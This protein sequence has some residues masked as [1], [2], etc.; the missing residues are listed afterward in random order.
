MIPS[1]TT[2]AGIAAFLGAENHRGAGWAAETAA[3]RES[4]SG[5]PHGQVRVFFNDTITASIVADNGPL[6]N[7]MPHTEGSMVVKELYGSGTSVIGHAAMLRSGGQYIFY[8][9]ASEAGLCFAAHAANEV[10]TVASNCACHTN[11]VVIT[12]W[13]Q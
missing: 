6:G 13:P 10:S 5:S 7:R 1:D 12:P 3:P 11:G 8:C 9:N 4:G 2:P